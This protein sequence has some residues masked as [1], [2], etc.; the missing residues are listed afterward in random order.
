M[1]FLLHS[2][3]HLFKAIPSGGGYLCPLCQTITPKEE[4]RMNVPLRN[5][6]DAMTQFEASQFR[7]CVVFRFAFFFGRRK[8]GREKSKNSLCW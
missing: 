5:L 6:L 3:D 4:I 2:Y 8:E 7:L 1:M